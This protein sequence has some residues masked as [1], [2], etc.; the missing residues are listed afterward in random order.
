MQPID[1]Y[2]YYFTEVG[3]PLDRRNRLW[4]EEA[5]LSPNQKETRS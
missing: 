2:G 4:T 5:L 1:A 3:S